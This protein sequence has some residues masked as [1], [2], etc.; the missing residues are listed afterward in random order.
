MPSGYV[1]LDIRTVLYASITS[2][3]VSLK[4]LIIDDHFEVYCSRKENSTSVIPSIFTLTPMVLIDVLTSSL[5]MVS[6][7]DILPLVKDIWAGLCGIVVILGFPCPYHTQFTKYQKHLGSER[8]PPV[9]W[10]LHSKSCAISSIH[11][12]ISLEEYSRES[13]LSFDI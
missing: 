8:F 6:L 5:F 2:M 10:S 1:M 7:V 13:S 12:V 4:A 9:E 11:F 3:L